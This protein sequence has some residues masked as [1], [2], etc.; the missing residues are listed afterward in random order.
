MVVKKVI[1]KVSIITIL[2]LV[3]IGVQAEVINLTE[4]VKLP[5]E[6]EHPVGTEQYN[7]SRL[8]HEELTSFE[9]YCTLGMI[10]IFLA[11]LIFCLTRAFKEEK[12]D[13]K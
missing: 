13:E 2:M 10:A 12:N 11:L 3:V 6:S 8:L 5:L 4:R 7:D 1:K 9:L